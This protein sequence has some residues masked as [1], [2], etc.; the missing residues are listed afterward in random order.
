MP[1]LVFE[2]EISSTL[3]RAY[4]TVLKDI[5][6]DPYLSYI[7]LLGIIT[8]SFWLWFRVPNFAGPDEYSR[9][10]QPMKVAGR[11]VAEPGFA[12]IQQAITDGR[13]LGATFYLYSLVL[14]PVFVYIVVTGQL[15]RF[16]SLG[17]IDS[18]WEL[19]QAA[20]EWFWASTILLGRLTSVILGVGCIYLTYRIGVRYRDRQT[21]QLAALLLTLSVGF[22][23]QAH[24]AG[25]D[26][27]M[28]FFF[29]LTLWIAITYVRSGNSNHFLLGCV[30]GGIAI[31]FKLTGGVAVFVLG[32]AHLYRATAT[33]D[34]LPT[35][36]NPKVVGGGLLVGIGTL[37]VGMPSVLVTGPETFIERVLFGLST[38]TGKTGVVEASVWYWIV[39][40]GL[41]ALGWPLFLAAVAG[42]VGSIIT[43]ARNKSADACWL[44]L[45]VG[46]G[47]YLTAYGT[48]NFVRSHHVLPMIP[49]ALLLFAGEASR[50]RSRHKRMLRVLVIL[51]VLSSFVFTSVGLF[52]YTTEPRDEATDWI[53]SNADPDA[54]IEVYENSVADVGVPH[55]T[56]VVHYNFDEQNA[57]DEPSLILNQ[58]AYTEWMV[59]IPDRQPDYIQ[60][61]DSEL[62]YLDPENSAARQYPKRRMYIEELLTGE[63]NY[64]VVAEFGTRS[65][66]ARFE[67]PATA[68]LQPSVT[69]RTNGVIILERTT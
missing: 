55:G 28:I 3:N 52:M 10:I 59:S 34:L 27:P 4:E 56:R 47:S 60:L 11:F 30:T 42:V 48:W 1:L 67:S 69:G 15:S 12:S 64:T 57:T 33:E 37:Y 29:L 45:V 53:R 9:L 46:L 65:Q 21:G 44:L 25:E 20:P 23:S 62:R 41:G 54:N 31:A 22:V 63:Y 6:S 50:F 18:R 49:L 38:K 16:A 35:L 39:I 7:L 19:W 13:A 8:M 58:S 61:T 40:Q 51:V 26:I 68:G 5:D 36:F 32:G 43:V 14:A 17:T 2:W 66:F 24:V